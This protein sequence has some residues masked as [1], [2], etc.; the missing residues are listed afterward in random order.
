[1]QA[2]LSQ[3]KAN[4]EIRDKRE[5]IH[6][7]V[8]EAVGRLNFTDAEF[9]QLKSVSNAATDPDQ[10]GEGYIEVVMKDFMPSFWRR[11]LF[12]TPS[13][14]LVMAE[15]Y[16]YALHAKER[17]N[18]VREIDVNNINQFKDR[19]SGMSDREAD[20][21]LNWFRNQERELENLNDIRTK[22]QRVIDDTNEVRRNSGLQAMFLRGSNWTNY[23][24]LRGAFDPEDETVDFN[25]AGQRK[26]PLFGSKGR[27]DPVVKGRIDYAPNLIVN[28]LTQNANSIM[29]AAQNNVGRVV[30]DDQRRPCDASRVCNHTGQCQKEC[31][32]MHEQGSGKRYTRDD[33]QKTNILIVKENGNEVV[34]RFNSAVV[35]GAFRGDT[36]AEMRK[37]LYLMMAN[38]FNRYLSS[39]NTTFNP[40]FIIPNFVRDVQTMTINIDQY[41]GERLKRI[42]VKRSPAMARDIYRRTEER[43]VLTRSTDVRCFCK[44][45]R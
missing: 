14:K 9:E 28:A 25:N 20:A 21:I 35:A 37:Q 23:I 38:K 22:I 18:Y 8:V 13:K 10:G 42:V 24:P 36:G 7:D 43:Y 41:G 16:L 31:L 39:I 27:E 1:M 29:R 34:I 3:G 6:K 40:E 19:G 33:M 12:G 4:E 2:R 44:S 45:R 11:M 30:L 32:W 15:T 5:T 17:N 26:A